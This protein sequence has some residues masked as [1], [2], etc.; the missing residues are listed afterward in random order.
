MRRSANYIQYMRT[1]L[2]MANG[3]RGET[4]EGMGAEHG[5]LLC[6]LPPI[7]AEPARKPVRG[8]VGLEMPLVEIKV[9]EG[10]A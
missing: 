6:G 4:A 2:R 7:D 3:G 9:S 5:E 8:E 1:T 10:K